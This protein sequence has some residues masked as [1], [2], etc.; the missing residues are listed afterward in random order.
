MAPAIDE[1]DA[2]EIGQCTRPLA[3]VDRLIVR[4]PQN[5]HS[6]GRN[7]GGITVTGGRSVLNPW[8]YDKENHGWR[9]GCR[10]PSAGG[11]ESRDIIGRG[12]GG[13]GADP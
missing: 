12:G 3:A 6:R 5:G 10:R 8:Q 1:V 2:G 13:R 9:D 7:S 11:G 4:S